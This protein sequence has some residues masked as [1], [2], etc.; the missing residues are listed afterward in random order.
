MYLFQTA[1]HCAFQ[2]LVMMLAMAHST[3]NLSCPDSSPKKPMCDVAMY[4]PALWNTPEDDSRS[5]WT[6]QTLLSSYNV[7]AS[8]IKI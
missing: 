3:G 4:L 5:C 6:S 8:Q 1:L 2:E 7:Q